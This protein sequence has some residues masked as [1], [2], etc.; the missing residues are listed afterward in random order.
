MGAMAMSPRS[1]R[2]SISTPASPAAVAALG[3]PSSPSSEASTPA[4]A[5]RPR[6]R[7]GRQLSAKS[8]VTS[9]LSGLWNVSSPEALETLTP[10]L[11]TPSEDAEQAAS[12]DAAAAASPS[13][14][15]GES[16]AALP[17]P[18]PLTPEQAQ[19]QAKAC[20]ILRSSLVRSLA[21][22]ALFISVTSIIPSFVCGVLCCAVVGAEQAGAA[23]RG[24]ALL[25]VDD[26]Q[27]AARIHLCP[28][29][30]RLLRWYAA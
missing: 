6:H 27:R 29:H 3:S 2:S 4:A 24:G 5:S 16:D 20:W 26:V 30:R 22:F 10:T 13:A 25:H 15:L 7:P 23:A 9:I 11:P 19:M 8:T 18:S 17:P 14:V 1:P 28:T 21:R 12:S